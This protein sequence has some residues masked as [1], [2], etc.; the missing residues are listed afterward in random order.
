[1]TKLE[2]FRAEKDE[3]FALDPQSPITPEN[4]RSFKGLNYYP[5]NPALRLEVKLEEFATKDIIKMQTTTQETQTYR[6]FG[7]FTFSIEGQQARLTIYKDRTGYFL[8]FVDGL[9]GKETYPAGRYLEPV[10]L[11]ESRFR[12]DFNLAYNPF[13]AYN[14]FYSCPLT[15]FENRVKVPIRAGEKIFHE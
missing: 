13:C 2:K 14:D 1:M 10:P 8:P 6:R 15:P 5:E 9:A 7:Q 3:F 11:G 12:I 4:R